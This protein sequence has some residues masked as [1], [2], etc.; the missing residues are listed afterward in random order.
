MITH[1]EPDDQ[2]FLKKFLPKYRAIDILIPM[3]R[4]YMGRT[5]IATP[6]F[7]DD[8]VSAI[9]YMPKHVKNFIW[10]ELK[11]FM[12]WDQQFEDMSNIENLPWH[13]K[14]WFELY[15]KLKSEFE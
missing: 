11:N 6:G 13:K 9:S 4:Y 1:K 15:Q 3:L 2:Q 5:S 10:N 8:L 12:E 7:A 14:I